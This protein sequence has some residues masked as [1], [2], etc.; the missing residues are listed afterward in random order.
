MRFLYTIFPLLITLSIAAQ[1][2]SKL[3]DVLK[4]AVEISI[5]DSILINYITLAK[6]D[7]DKTTA[8]S[9]FKLIYPNEKQANQEVEYFVAGKIT[10]HKDFDIL[11][12]CT[13]KTTTTRYTID[14]EPTSLD[15]SIIKELYFVLLDKEGNYKNNF[16]GAM[17][18]ETINYLQKNT[19]RKISS[20]IYKDFK[21]VQYV[22]AEPKPTNYNILPFVKVETKTINLSMEYHINDYGVFVAYPKFKYN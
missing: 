15:Y 14:W 2:T 17:N 4:T 20:W 9:F 22:E 1:K 16:L 7:L 12:L 19:K 6:T 5:S 11:L 3:K 10:S 21:I 13:E 8:E 18:Y